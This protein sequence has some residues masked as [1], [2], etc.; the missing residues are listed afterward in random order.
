[1]SLDYISKSHVKHMENTRVFRN[2]NLRNSWAMSVDSALFEAAQILVDEDVKLSEIPDSNEL[3]IEFLKLV[4]MYL[5]NKIKSL[6]K[7]RLEYLAGHMKDIYLKEKEKEE[8][9]KQRIIAEENRQK[10]EKA[11][12]LLSKRTK[13]GQPILKNLAKMQLEQ[14]QRMIESEKSK[15]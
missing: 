13:K 15:K 14:V 10:R 9:Q 2:V 12:K 11:K 3:K 4:Q 6:E 5:N 1:M 8:R 7:A